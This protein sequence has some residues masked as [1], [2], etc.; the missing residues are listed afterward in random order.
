MPSRRQWQR[1][2]PRLTT[3]VIQVSASINNT[4]PSGNGTVT[5]YGT[6]ITGVSVANLPMTA[7]GHYKITT[8]YCS[9]TTEWPAPIAPKPADRPLSESSIACPSCRVG[10]SSAFAKNGTSQFAVPVVPLFI[11]V[12]TGA[13]A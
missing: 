10:L 7:A 1:P 11:I 6:P 13:H 9:G 4:T 3:H 5:V 12:V 8:S 2:Q